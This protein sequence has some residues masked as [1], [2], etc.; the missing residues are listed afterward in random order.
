MSFQQGCTDVISAG[1]PEQTTKSSVQS[2][3]IGDALVGDKTG[4]L[5]R[6]DAFVSPAA[7]AS[8]SD[9]EVETSMANIY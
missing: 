5:E 3:N 1:L 8:Q 4:A 6:G 9:A 7:K 2:L